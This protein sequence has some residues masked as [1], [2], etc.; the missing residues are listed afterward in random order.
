MKKPERLIGF[1]KY[2]ETEFPFEFDEKSFSIMLYPPTLEIWKEHSDPMK[3][4]ESF[5]RDEKTHKWIS[6]I[7]L[8]GFTSEKHQIIFNV[9]EVNSNYHGFISFKVNWY[10]CHTSNMLN[11]SI[12]GFRILGH[13][14]NLF[15]PPQIALESSIEFNEN[16]KGI[17]KISVNSKKQQ[18]ESCG[19]Y[20]ISKHID[21]NI[22]VTAYA[23]FHSNTWINPI[24]S[25]SCMITTFST[26]VGINTIIDAYYNLRRFFEYV[27]YRKNVELGDLDLFFKN[28]EGLRDYSG[29]IVFPNENKKESHKK[30]KDQFTQES[31]I[32]VVFCNR[33]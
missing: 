12:D 30:V 9:Q 29:I 21:V 31:C 8:S 6:N 14:V 15:Y 24:D 20:C 11:D 19:R 17:E 28:D 22:E 23:S 16:G 5:N 32:S 33:K 4:F 25:I 3:I 2:N 26:P 1:I 10:V 27:T 18:I 13:D 7:E